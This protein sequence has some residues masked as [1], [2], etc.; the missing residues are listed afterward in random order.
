MTE[1]KRKTNDEL[2]KVINN[3]SARLE[4]LSNKLSQ[5]INNFN[6]E[7]LLDIQIE[8]KALKEEVKII[9][10][11]CN[12]EKNDKGIASVYETFKSNY[13]EANAY[14]FN[15]Q[16]NSR[17]SEYLLESVEEAYDKLRSHFD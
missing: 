11:Y 17:N 5:N 7:L 6:R 1:Y 9:A 12:L 16:V 14:G 10:H 2:F 4:I 8:Y 15:T 3:H 13:L